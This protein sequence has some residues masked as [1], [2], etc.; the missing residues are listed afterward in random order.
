MVSRGM[1]TSRQQHQPVTGL[2]AELCAGRG[3]SGVCKSNG[4]MLFGE[5]LCTNRVAGS[6]AL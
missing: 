2:V 6:G 5:P 3:H 4:L 1:Q